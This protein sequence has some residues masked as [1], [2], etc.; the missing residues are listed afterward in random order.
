MSN[1]E[2]ITP[3]DIEYP[4]YS[5]SGS[6][7]IKKELAEIIKNGKGKFKIRTSSGSFNEFITPKRSGQPNG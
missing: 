4:S 7:R 2:K 6:R 1:E 3:I 5:E